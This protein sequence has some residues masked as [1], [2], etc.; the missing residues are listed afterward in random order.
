[1]E[2]KISYLQ[3]ILAYNAKITQL[4]NRMPVQIDREQIY[5]EELTKIKN[6]NLFR[7]T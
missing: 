5:Q 6:S 7:C 4:K 2:K 3:T 1:V